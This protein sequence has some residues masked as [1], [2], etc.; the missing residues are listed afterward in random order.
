[1]AQSTRDG[2]LN[3]V[4]KPRAARADLHNGVMTDAKADVIRLAMSRANLSHKE[5]SYLMGQTPAQTTRQ[6][7]GQE[8]L[9]FGRMREKLP[10]EF[11]RELMI[12][13]APT[14]GFVIER[15]LILKESA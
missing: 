7:N 5:F 10:N 2:H 9:P 11:W 1:M 6:L 3:T 4:R 13:L 12:L 14:V 8:A 15:T